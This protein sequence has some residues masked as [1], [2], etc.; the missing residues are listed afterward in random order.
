[1]AISE[2]VAASTATQCDILRH[3][4]YLATVEKSPLTAE[5]CQATVAM[6]DRML[7]VAAAG[8]GKTSVMVAKVGYA[9][10]TGQY[11]A[12]QILVLA[13][14]NKAAQEL[15][16]RI[17]TRLRHLIPVGQQ[18]KTKTFHALGLEVI[19]A[20][21]GMRPDVAVSTEGSALTDN[22]AL[23]DLIKHSVQNDADF[24]EQ[25]LLFRLFYCRELRSP[26]HFKRRKQWLDFVRANG[27][28]LGRHLGFLSLNGD[29]LMC[30]CELAVANWLYMQGVPYNYT[31]MRTNHSI[32]RWGRPRP[33][34]FLLLHS[35]CWVLVSTQ[36][37]QRDTSSSSMQAGKQLHISFDDLVSGRLFRRLRM[38][39]TAWGQPVRPRTGA[40]MMQRLGGDMSSDELEFLRAFIH[41]ARSNALDGCSLRKRVAQHAQADRAGTL[42]GFLAALLRAHASQIAQSN[43]LDFQEMIN[44]ASQYVATGRYRHPYR[45]ILVDEFQD[46]SQASAAL[47]KTL[48]QQ[49]P[50]CKLFAV[51]DDWQSIYRFAGADTRLFTHFEEYFGK[52]SKYFLRASF[53]FNQG[54]ADV[55][56]EFIQHNPD[57]LKK[58][59]VAL[60][61]DR[62]DS[63]VITHYHTQ[64][65]MLARCLLCLDEIQQYASGLAVTTVYI[66]GRYRHQQPTE[67]A[68]W[69][70]RFPGLQLE[71]KT[72]HAAKGLEADYVLV[73]GLQGGRYAFP[74]EINAN[75]LLQ[76]VMPD[77]ETWP[78]AEERRLL[79]VAMTRA[80]HKVYLVASALVPS[81]FVS[82][83]A[84][85]SGVLNTGAMT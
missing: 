65:E 80:R 67:L 24:A 2:T 17:H 35:Q 15:Q 1:M 6:P 73:L 28:G 36:A 39:L 26:A 27:S 69:Q 75:P 54:I 79:Y 53:R 7:L 10:L 20:V 63:V 84:K 52:A 31:S 56:T 37:N 41:H 25:W 83:L 85:Y 62:T 33:Q 64:A 22:V 72:I 18:V 9:L 70:T 38:A 61:T 82:E 44:R 58:Q 71:F 46:T 32:F 78:D 47:I 30:Q 34:G 42:T 55:A 59:V 45:L 48:L 14:N 50:S 76:L 43:V 60:A 13:F 77:A 4:H 5:Q 21:Q 12:G 11:Q 3:Q 81:R 68:Q 23:N 51:G 8:S 29:M 74:S 57:Q 40:Y 49:N 66:L 19:S 16:E